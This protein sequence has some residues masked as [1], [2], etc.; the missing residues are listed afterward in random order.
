MSPTKLFPVFV[1]GTLKRGE[2]NHNYLTDKNKGFAKFICSGKTDIQFP[3]IIATKYNIP[4][5][6]NAPGTGSNICGEIYSIDESM[7][8][9][10]DGLEDYPEI[11]DR[12]VFDVN[13]SD[14]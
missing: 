14:G 4:F 8:Q 1:Y 10:L 12:N 2:P 11:Y 9:H 13:G 5:M 3:L 6:L 7:L